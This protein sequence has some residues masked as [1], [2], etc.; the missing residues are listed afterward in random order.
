MSPTQGVDFDRHKNRWI[1]NEHI[2]LQLFEFKVRHIQ[3]IIL[4]NVYRPPSGKTDPFIQALTQVLQS[5]DKLSEFDIFVIG[6]FN[7]PY[8]QTKPIT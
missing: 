8:N 2:E 6:D 4:L 1:C 5:F 3:K 7:L